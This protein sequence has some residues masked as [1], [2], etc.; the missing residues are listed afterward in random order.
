MYFLTHATRFLRPGGRLQVSD[1]CVEQEVPEGA[2]ADT[3]LW[4]A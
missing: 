1:I 3:D 4:T 2:K